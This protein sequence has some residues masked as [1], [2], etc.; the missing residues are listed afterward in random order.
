[1]PA[2][3]IVDVTITDP[4]KYEDYKKLAAPTVGAYGGKYIV[5]GGATQKLEGSWSPGRCVILEF[6]SVER[7]KAW[8]DS[9]EYRP[10]RKL[11]DAAATTNMLMVE[12]I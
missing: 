12:G 11:R 10:A 4:V 9:E 3:I 8:H 7:A 1:M 6:P 5:R 2:Y